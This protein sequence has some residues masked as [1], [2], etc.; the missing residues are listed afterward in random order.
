MLSWQERVMLIV[1]VFYQA[2]EDRMIELLRLGASAEKVTALLG[3]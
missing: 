1:S 3:R 2:K